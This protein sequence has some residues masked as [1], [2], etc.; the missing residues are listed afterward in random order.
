MALLRLALMR[1]ICGID[2]DRDKTV[3]SFAAFKK[4]TPIFLRDVTLDV[5]SSSGIIE[6]LK[7]NGNLIGRK[8]NDKSKELAVKIDR[9][10]LCLGWETGDYRLAE[11]TTSF[12]VI[13]RVSCRDIEHIR[14]RIEDEVLARDEYCV[15]N[16]DMGYELDDKIY[17]RVPV[18]MRAKRLKVRS[19]V[20]VI[21]EN[22]YR[23]AADVFSRMD[24]VFGGF[25]AGPPAAMAA[26]LPMLEQS[27][28]LVVVNMRYDKSFYLFYDQGKLSIGK[29]IDFGLRSVFESLQNNFSIPFFLTDEVFSR[30][31]SFKG[32]DIAGF[33]G[34]DRQKEITL[35]DGDS[36]V[37]VS[38]SAINAFLAENLAK[39]LGSMARSF[40]D[41]LGGSLDLTFVGRLSSKD[42]FYSFLRSCMPQGVGV[43]PAP[44]AISCAW[45]AT[46]YGVKRFLENAYREKEPFLRRLIRTYKEYF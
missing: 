20:M 11:D 12:D 44:G 33:S 5:A 39:E 14:D 35:K 42:G 41:S 27:R 34:R 24:L 31:L 22:L 29:P 4:G 32:A 23:E 17:V 9:V 45:G 30:Y 2:I 16:F 38:I 40:K 25:I 8:I 6:Y 46:R 3:L 18:G 7:A 28:R 13:K 21:K 26:C 10:F 36:Y 19:L 1:G 37:N 15:H 43:M